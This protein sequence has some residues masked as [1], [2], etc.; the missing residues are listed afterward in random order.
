MTRYL[1][2]HIVGSY[3]PEDVMILSVLALSSKMIGLS[4]NGVVTKPPTTSQYD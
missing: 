2:R 1:K 3:N 4:K